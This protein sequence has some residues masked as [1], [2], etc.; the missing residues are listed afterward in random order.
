MDGPCQLSQQLVEYTAD[1]QGEKRVVAD[2]QFITLR[3]CVCVHAC[4]YTVQ[5]HHPSAFFLLSMES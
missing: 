3:H 1:L 5:S 2:S 4:V